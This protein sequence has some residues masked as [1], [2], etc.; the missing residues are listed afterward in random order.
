MTAREHHEVHLGE[1]Q[2]AQVHQIHPALI[3]RYGAVYRPQRQAALKRAR[4]A[5]ADLLHL[6]REEIT[7]KRP[8]TLSLDQRATF[9]AWRD[10]LDELI[11]IMTTEEGHHG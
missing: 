2:L 9:D 5:S 10:V 3:R 1:S 8:G 4:G 6:M 11:E 7:P